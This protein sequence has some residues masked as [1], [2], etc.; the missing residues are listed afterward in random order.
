[1]VAGVDSDQPP[2]FRKKWGQ[3]QAEASIQLTALPNEVQ[4]DN[5]VSDQC[6]LIEVFTFDRTGLLYQLAQRLHDLSLV[7]HQAKIGTSLDQVVDVF[8]VTDREG[9]KILDQE[10]LDHIRAQ[11]F[12]VITS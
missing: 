1:L 12:E 6:T 11:M 5:G 7:I 4:I 8:Y 3:E 2:R 9:N 10:R